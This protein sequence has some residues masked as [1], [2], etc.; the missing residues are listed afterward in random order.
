MTTNLREKYG[1]V[2]AA[3]KS[4][5]VVNEQVA[6]ATLDQRRHE[7]DECYTHLSGLQKTA[8]NSHK[9]FFDVIKTLT[10]LAFSRN[11]APQDVSEA[12]EPCNIYASA[13]GQIP[14]AKD[15]LAKAEE[16][17]GKAAAELGVA[18]EE[19]RSISYFV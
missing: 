15:D 6:K 4:D 19:L 11:P 10:K 13:A 17:A 7:V 5:A 9:A 12:I 8:S 14:I 18:S 3:I 16:A 1:N 2:F